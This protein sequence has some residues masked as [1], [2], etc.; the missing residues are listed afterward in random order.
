MDFNLA[1]T[2][3]GEI[4]EHDGFKFNTTDTTVMVS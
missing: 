2:F 1:K 3:T 4:T